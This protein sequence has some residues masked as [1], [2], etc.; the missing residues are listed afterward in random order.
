MKKV[1]F[2]FVFILL[3]TVCFAQFSRN[4][5]RSIMIEHFLKADVEF[6]VYYS[7]K[8]SNDN[9]NRNNNLNVPYKFGMHRDGY[10]LDGDSYSSSIK[11][12]QMV[13]LEELDRHLMYSVILFNGNNIQAQKNGAILYDLIVGYTNYGGKPFGNDAIEWGPHFDNSVDYIIQ[14]VLEV[15]DDMI[16]ISFLAPMNN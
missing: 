6:H 3:N 2:Y 16:C 10:E 15:I 8:S 7:I 9:Y 14:V 5:L 11:G 1:V 4:E 12:N 13:A